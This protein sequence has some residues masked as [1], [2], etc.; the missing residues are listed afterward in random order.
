MLEVTTQVI[1]RVVDRDQ[2]RRGLVL[3]LRILRVVTDDYADALE[4]MQLIRT[5]LIG[6]QLAFDILIK[7][8]RLG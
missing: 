2:R 7:R 8:L 4:N 1:Q 6:S 3:T 5:A